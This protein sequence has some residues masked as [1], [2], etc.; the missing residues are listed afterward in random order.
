MKEFTKW[1]H[2]RKV[3]LRCHPALERQA[4]WLLRVFQELADEG[5]GLWAGERVQ[6]GW[7]FL[8]L[9]QESSQW[10]VC[11]PDFSRDPFR[12]IR[13]DV[14]CTLTVQAQQNDV[15]RRVGVEL[16]EGCPTF[17]DRILIGEGCLDIAKIYLERVEAAGDHSGWYVGPVDGDVESRSNHLIYE[18]V[19]RRFELLQV[20]ALP[21]GY[22]AVFEGKSIKAILNP[23]QED[24]WTRH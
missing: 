14:T 7:S 24:V 21:I 2:E 10:I 11:E 5:K 16:V 18:L 23:A 4:D 15:L 19:S 1:I 17:Q 20:L 12:E 8:T 22:L 13:D 6:V 3:I 9:R